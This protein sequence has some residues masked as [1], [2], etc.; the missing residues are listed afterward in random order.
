MCMWKLVHTSVQGRGHVRKNIPCQD[1]TYAISKNDVSTIVLAD[2]A[3]SACYSHY[4]AECV[5]QIVGELLSDKFE[6]YFQES[7]A[8]L[9]KKNLVDNICQE[10]RERA[11]DLN[12]DV[13]ELA[14]T[15]LAVAVK[16]EDFLIV[17]LGDGVIGY[18]RDGDLKVASHPDNGEFCNTTTFT[19]SSNAMHSM[20]LLKG[21]LNNITGFI[22]FSDGTESC[23]YNST[24]KTIVQSI[25]NV[26]SDIQTE[27]ID[28][29]ENDLKETLEEI[30]T[31]TLDD[32][33]IAIM[34]KCDSKKESAK[35]NSQELE[36]KEEPV[37][38]I[39]QESDITE[40]PTKE[41]SIKPKTLEEEFVEPESDKH[42]KGLP[43]TIQDGETLLVAPN[44][45][46]TAG[47]H[48]LNERVESLN[49]TTKGN[50]KSTMVIAIL[51]V[52]ILLLLCK[53]FN[54]F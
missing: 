4:G 50:R 25:S 26:F 6:S 53:L 38:I 14:S 31:R 43:N 21:Q 40:E 52:I 9:V 29:V 46:K 51:L 1:K 11:I 44:Y 5:T 24:T 41:A 30:K 54:I 45:G 49:C 37:A 12:C 28:T 36:V 35:E 18:F 20:K 16:G 19:T 8:S 7:N 13:K 33:S 2:G 3:G 10:L 48:E 22:L 17:H 47:V 39:L 27:E 32:C 34:C 15:L 23:L 42:E